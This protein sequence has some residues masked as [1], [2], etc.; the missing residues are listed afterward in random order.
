VE[1]PLTSIQILFQNTP[2]WNSKCVRRQWCVMER[3]KLFHISDTNK[4]PL[5]NNSVENWEHVFQCKSDVAKIE[6]LQG[7]MTL[8]KTMLA[9]KT[10]NLLS[11]W[12]IALVSQITQGYKV[13]FSHDED[14][15]E[16]RQ[17]FQ[18]I[19]N[20]GEWNF[21][22]GVHPNSLEYAQ[23]QHYTTIPDLPISYSGEKW[24]KRMI[25]AVYE[26]S[27]GLW[28]H[29]CDVI[30][31]NQVETVEIRTK[32]KAQELLTFYQCWKPWMLRNEDRH[33]LKRSIFCMS[34]DRSI[35]N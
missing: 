22:K 11:N 19:Q 33:L 14:N 7:I 18:D 12:I 4:C 1:S 2:I 35:R 9:M 32:M 3:A 26:F 8:K 23:Q 25:S 27:H 20:L 21:L 29:R 28:V 13:Q 5:C 6:R 10:S 30:H 15:S 17:A 16:I 34:T 31:T 24:P